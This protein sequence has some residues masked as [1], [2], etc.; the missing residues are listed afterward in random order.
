M[1]CAQQKKTF[2]VGRPKLGQLFIQWLFLTDLM[3][4]FCPSATSARAGPLRPGLILLSSEADPALS[5]TPI[6]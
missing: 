4:P 1:T 6:E 3:Y 2:G 5:A